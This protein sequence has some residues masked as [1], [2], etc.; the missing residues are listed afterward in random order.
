MNRILAIARMQTR[1][2]PLALIPWGI[3]TA[4]LGANIAILVIIR[5]QGVELPAQQFN[6][7]VSSIFFFVAA[8][9]GVAMTQL[10]PFALGLGVTR[11][12]FF[13]GTL[14]AAAGHGVLTAAA[15][16]AMAAIES[17][18]DGFGVHLR[19]FSA[20]LW[21]SGNYALVFLGLAAVVIVCAAIGMFAGTVY[22][23]WKAVGIFTLSL[24]VAIAAA[25]AA[26]LITWQRG[27]PAVGRFFVDS[28]AAVPLIALPL[29]LTVLAFAGGY[30][31][32]RRA[33]V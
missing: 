5:G 14:V 26:V 29:A 12:E 4:V 31:L 21:V 23:R 32:L 2:W 8:T 33:E 30:G 25:A 7:V 6:G 10:F 3:I 22:L 9:Y 18:T 28:P 11:R 13:G 17:G 20:V 15:L 16:T 19:A 27:W 1:Q 24:L